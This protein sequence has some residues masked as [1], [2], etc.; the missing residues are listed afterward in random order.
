[1]LAELVFVLAGYVHLPALLLGA[2]AYFGYSALSP[3]V[4]V[5]SRQKEEDRGAS[6]SARPTL[7]RTR[8]SAGHAVGSVFCLALAAC[9]A[10]SREPPEPASCPAVVD[11]AVTVQAVGDPQEASR[12]PLS[13]DSVSSSPQDVPSQLLQMARHSLNGEAAEEEEKIMAESALLACVQWAGDGHPVDELFAQ[14]QCHS[15]LLEHFGRK[16]DVAKLVASGRALVEV[17]ERRAGG[18]MK[19]S[20]DLSAA[21]VELAR[22]M[23]AALSAQCAGVCDELAMTRKAAHNATAIQVVKALRSVRALHQPFEEQLAAT[24]RSIQELANQADK[25]DSAASDELEELLAARAKARICMLQAMKETRLLALALPPASSSLAEVLRCRGLSFDALETLALQEGEKEPDAG[26]AFV[27]GEYWSEIAVTDGPAPLFSVQASSRWVPDGNS[28]R[29]YV[30]QDIAKAELFLKDAEGRSIG[31]SRGDRGAMRA[32]RLYHHAK[33]LVR[34]QLDTAA[35][36]RYRLSAAVAVGHRRKKLAAHSLARLGYFLVI[37]GRQETAL[38]AVMEA[39]SYSKDPLA[40]YL[41]AT[42]RRSAGVLQTTEDVEAARAEIS[43]VSGKL[44]SQALERQR[45]EQHQELEWWAHVSQGTAWACL[46][47][48]NVAH[49]FICLFCKLVWWGQDLTAEAEEQL[50]EED[51]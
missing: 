23:Q 18:D 31:K 4:V 36:L 15:D 11:D 1:M 28:S 30:P 7:V 29:G 41:G 35:E 5:P 9:C 38:E 42:L 3:T 13:D 17:V 6:R 20:G 49:V 16:H 24:G 37:R 47:A 50:T 14:L 43:S 8:G 51:L 25:G 26:A 21:Q 12:M 45:G 10:F 34:Q 46:Q 40:V 2:A 19:G 44:P 39:Q 22:I 33:Y 27:L 48:Q 32:L